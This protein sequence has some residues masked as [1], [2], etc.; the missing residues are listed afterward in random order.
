MKKQGPVMTT[1]FS[2]LQK[3]KT[4]TS[5]IIQLVSSAQ[6]YIYVMVNATVSIHNAKN[7]CRTIFSCTVQTSKIQLFGEKYLQIN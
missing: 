2:Q 3:L 1:L 5:H 6:V 7:S 4:D